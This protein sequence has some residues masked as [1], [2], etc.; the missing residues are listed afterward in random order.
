MR[1]NIK[2]LFLI[3]LFISSEVLAQNEAII[4][5]QLMYTSRF[6]WG[7]NLN[8]T[9]LG[10]INF[11]YGWHKTGT[12]NNMLDF[13]FARIRNSK[14]IQ[15]SSAS[16]NP[17]QYVFGRLNMAFFLR[18]GYGQNIAI[19][20][21][22]YKNAASLHFNYSLGATC[23]F[24]KPIFVDVQVKVNDPNQVPYMT[25]V[26]MQYDP[27]T[28]SQSDILGESTFTEGISKTKLYPGGYGKA[29]LAVE[30]GPYPDEFKSLEAGVVLD[31][32][33]RPLPLMANVSP[34][35]YFFTLFIEFTFGS[36]N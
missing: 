35:F 36:N 20:E 14:E 6:Q 3:C 32:F 27:A 17:R 2:S 28:V 26:P 31:A 16:D 30:W 4:Q 12:V 24:L 19:T 7:G 34:E 5:P 25:V 18:A 21:R 23:A 8:S 13:E 22:P 10:G 33:L 1:N 15:T 29:S 11:K 9:G